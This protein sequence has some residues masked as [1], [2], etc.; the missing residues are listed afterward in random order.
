MG[1]VH[2]I[3]WF[4]GEKEFGKYSGNIPGMLKM[5]YVA[6][7][8]NKSGVQLSVFSLSKCSGF[9]FSKTYIQNNGYCVKYSS[10]FG[11]KNKLTKYIDFRYKQ[12]QF[13]LYILFH[14]KKQDTILLY[15]S[16]PYTTLLSRL[17]KLIKRKVI[18]EVEE[19]YG[20]SAVKDFDWVKTELNSINN[21][22]YFMFVNSGMPRYLNISKEK[23][24]VSYGVGN[25][26]KRKV[27]RFADGKIHIVYAG[28]IEQR[29]LGALT[30]VECA[31]YLSDKYVMH[32]L[33]FGNKESIALMQDKI[34]ENNA[35]E[36]R[37]PIYYEGYKTGAELDDFLFKCHIGIST[38]V[39]R[40]NFAN[41]SFPSKVITYMCHDLTV[42]LGYAD[43]FK[44][45]PFVDGWNF[46]YDH[47]PEAIAS[48][49]E[50]SV[51][52][53]EGYYIPLIESMN[54]DLQLFIKKAA[55]S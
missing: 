12:L 10:G 21:M 5:R 35:I 46:Y 14:V 22:D 1:M 52:V 39:M 17:R 13:I 24:V 40:P 36:S 18:L 16:V 54:Q 6:E 38:N 42:V 49:I 33:G 50:K 4:I 37:C 43:A 7:M 45:A 19:I 48:A 44:D 27:E 15:H 51:L 55:I 26:P 11:W 34:K 9:K 28:T 23:Y 8:I 29:K 25:I 31:K 53:R 30:A 2:Y 3:G 47:S 20:Y 32:I 41:N